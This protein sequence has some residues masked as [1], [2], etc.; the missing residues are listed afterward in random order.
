MQLEKIPLSDTH[1]FSSFFLD[2][3][4]DPHKLTPFFHRS[5]QLENFE[6]Q[7]ADKS[8]F[9]ATHRSILVETLQRQYLHLTP[10][11]RVKSNILSLASEKTFTVTT[12]HQLT[13]FTG[14]LYFIYKIVTVINTC[15]R[16][17]QK[18]P[19]YSF[20]PVYWMATE[21]HDFAE[22]SSFRLYGKKYQWETDQTGAVGRFNPKT[23]GN[24]LREIPGDTRLFKDAYLRHDTLSDAVRYYIHKLFGPDGLVVIDADDRSLKSLF[25]GVM[26]DDLFHHTTKGLVDTQ[27]S[28]LEDLGYYPQVHARE[29]N[30][31]YLDAGVRNRLEREG[32]GFKVVDHDLRFSFDQIRDLIKK[33]PEKLSPNVVLRP[34]YQ[35]TILP[36]LAYAGG[37]AEIVYWLQLKPVFDHFKVT[38]PILIPRNFGLVMDNP[39]LR[40]FEKTGLELK[41]LFEEK[42]YLFNHWVLKN[43]RH[44]LTLTDSIRAVREIFDLLKTRVTQLDVTLGPAAE[45]EKKRTVN[46]LEKMEKKMLKAEKRRHS[47]KLHQIEAV[48]DVLLPG[49]S[50]QERADNFLNFYQQDPDFIRHLINIFDPFDFRLHVLMYHD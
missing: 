31:F 23:I 47:D 33:E 16:L 37:P 19:E 42:N 11:D 13:I 44:N 30:F 10:N 45:A 9:P 28:K 2:Y 35:E 21:D 4:Q 48:K 39:T 17:R 24:L 25:E 50:L 26:E 22:I 34:L 41:D 49:G 5:P 18:Y 38:F 29:I 43:T 1:A 8:T 40:K 32:T 3:I 36:N 27:N 20:V 14:P 7:F 46:S 15:T 6:K 12:G